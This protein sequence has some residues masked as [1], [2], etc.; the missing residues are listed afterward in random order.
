[1]RESSGG[2]TAA[3]AARLTGCTPAQVD[4]WRR[5]ALVVPEAGGTPPAGTD[6]APYTFR[7]LVALRMVASLLDSGVSMSRVRRAVGELVRAGEDIASLSLVSEGDTVLACRDDG[8]VLDAFR[9]GQLVL[10]VSVARLA[11]EV[12]GEVSAF[13]AERSAFV[14]GLRAPSAHPAGDRA[15]GS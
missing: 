3:Q 12:E 4:M 7:D 6:P 8:Q 1:M 11:G 14:A 5:I 9:S 15:D 13:D 10:F 2:Y